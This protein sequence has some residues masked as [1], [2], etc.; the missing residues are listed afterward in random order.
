MENINLNNNDKSAS[1]SLKA[2]MV[3]LLCLLTTLPMSAQNRIV[4][5]TVVDQ[6]GET[7]IG[8]NV[9]VNGTTRGVITDI[10]GE[11]EIAADAKEKLTISFI[12]YIDAVVTAD[13]TSLKITLKEDS[14][15]LEEVVVVGYGTQKKATLTGAVSA[16]N[17]KEIAVTKNENV[18]N[19]LSGKIPGV[20][21]SQKSSQ[22]GEFD[23]AIDIRG[24]GE[25]LI[26][27]DGIPRDKAYFSRMDA[28]EIDNVSVLKDA[29]AAIY[30]VRAANGVI[31]VTTKHGEASNGKF[32]ITF[33]AN[34]GW[35]Q[36]LYV[37]QTASAADHMLLINEKYYNAFGDNT[38]PNRTPAKYTW[39]DMM[40][41]STGR[42]KSTNWTKELFDDNVPQQQYNVSVNGGSEKVNYFFN[43]ASL[44]QEG[45]YKSGSLNYDRWNFRSNI[46]AKITNRLKA[47]IQTSGYMDEKN[48]PFTDIWSVYKKAWTYRPTS[49]AYVDGDHN[50]PAW[51]SEM[52]EPENPVAATNS[53]LTGYRREKRYN[54]NG[55]LALTYDIPGVKGLSAKA[56]YSYDYYT[57]NNTSYKRAYKLYNKREDGTMESFDRNADSNLR[58]NT[59][60]SYGTVMQL[61][62]N[63]ANKFGD[64]NVGAM[65]LFEEQY[66]N[67]DNFYAQRVMLL[68]GEYL[69]YGEEKD[70]IGSMGGA[71][72]KTRQSVVGKV[73]YDYKG[74]YMVDFAF[75]YDGS[76]SFPKGSRWGFF[77]SVSAG[78]RISEEAFMKEL[79]PFLTNLKLRGSYG[80]MGDDGGA[81]TYP[82]NVVAYNIEKD[83]IG[84]FYNGALMA[85]VAATSIPNPDLT[86]YTAETYNLGLDFDLWNQKL[87]GTFEVFKRKRSGLLDTSSTIIPGTVGA[88]LPKENLNSDQTFGWEISLNHRNRVA[89]V[90]YWV[91]GQISA[92][93]NRWD[94]RQDSQASNS[95]DAW[96][97]RDVSG[98]NK[99]IW[100]S[101]EEGG[102]FSS[103]EQIRYHNVTGGGY[104]QGTLPGDYY[105]KD[106]NGD[107]IING[108]DNHPMATYNLPVFNYGFVMGAEWKGIDLSL[109]WQGAAGVYNSYTEVFTEVGPFN[110]GAVLDI[111]LDRWHTANPSDDPFNP[112][113]QWVSG[114]YP[115]T[116]HSFSN[117]G[118]GI[119]NTS[120]LRLKTLEIGYTL[121]KTWLAKA[122]IKDLRVYFNAYNLLTFTGLDNID[123]ER[124]GARG[125]VNDDPNKDS[126]LFYNYPVNRSFNI[127]ATLKF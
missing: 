1:F 40:E 113:T 8:A 56:F 55:A 12:G 111:Y 94:Y 24:M 99:D 36:F 125:D 6:T 106:W 114:L 79:V 20:R 109:N 123:P 23:N 97:R 115:A 121:P 120:Y 60:P 75:R 2:M 18:V 61:S 43:L 46:D 54:F 21:I 93:K 105:Y 14:Q 64:H 48:Q 38:Y 88:S 22:P 124:P 89:G 127:G 4:R 108:D 72:D 7:V 69:I 59:D 84:W 25:P 63:Y 17:N 104:G 103:Y 116:G 11:F 62:L 87:S 31:L 86:W 28:N 37:P 107:G 29:S 15:A 82:Q 80:K 77:P 96:R 50:Y 70:Q 73:N 122:G 119:K 81:N 42:K 39:Q 92:T 51:D 91:G 76:S 78:W 100:F 110:G 52:G 126:V 33:S 34:Y 90:N 117:A 45:S 65:V 47:T 98:R 9:R 13:K 3:A 26:V 10:N 83:K 5:G 49:E 16:I 67:W 95:M 35:Q 112:N 19:M 44:K 30:G 57:T 68:D 53:D 85:G 66:N 102:R 118:T 27:V 101:Y 32:D 71:G 74:R 58:R 41:Y